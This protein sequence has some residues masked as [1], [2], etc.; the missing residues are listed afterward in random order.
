M[1]TF[2][3]NIYSWF[4]RIGDFFNYIFDAASAGATYLYDSIDAVITAP[5]SSGILD[6]V[7]LAITVCVILL[8]L[9]R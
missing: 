9:G 5:L 3:E 4:G 8:V 7:I 2:L 6:V 1:D